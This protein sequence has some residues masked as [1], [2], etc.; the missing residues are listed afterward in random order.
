MLSLCFDL[1]FCT[2]ICRKSFL[3]A[4][5]A[6]SWRLI[7]GFSKSLANLSQMR[8]GGCKLQWYQFLDHESP[9]Y[10]RQ[11][12]VIDCCNDL[13][14]V[15]LRLSE[16]MLAITLYVSTQICNH[17]SLQT[18]CRVPFPTWRVTS[19]CL[20]HTSNKALSLSHYFQ[21]FATALIR[22]QVAAVTWSLPLQCCA[23][24][25]SIGQLYLCFTMLVTVPPT[26]FIF[27]YAFL[28]DAKVQVSS[29]SLLSCTFWWELPVDFDNC[30][31]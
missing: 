30:V 19:S 15:L 18:C 24:V 13:N 23:R 14:A 10:V 16:V 20:Q 31:G 5:S 27:W 8:A 7:S 21:R 17:G 3:F 4:S 22:L 2:S 12:A 9:L 1:K 26:T 11:V 29:W 6:S 28:T 25:A